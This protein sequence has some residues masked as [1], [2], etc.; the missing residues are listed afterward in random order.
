MREMYIILGYA[1]WIWFG[2]VLI[3]L[4]LGFVIKGRRR[5]SHGFEVI[6]KD[7]KQP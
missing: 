2:A 7:E 3:L 5:Q 6:V 4:L 1:G